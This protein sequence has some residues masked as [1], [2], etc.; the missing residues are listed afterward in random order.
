MPDSNDDP[1]ERIATLIADGADVD[2]EYWRRSGRLTEPELRALKLIESV[3]RAPDKSEEIESAEAKPGDPETGSEVELGRG[4]YGSVFRTLDPLLRREVAVKVLGGGEALSRHDRERFLREARLL[5]TVD[6]PNIVRIYSVEELD[7]EVRLELEFVP[8]S[9]LQE[10]VK[11]RGPLAPVEA[12]HVALDLCRAL[13]AIHG[14]GIVHRDLK[15]S[16][17]IRAP[18]GRIVLL[19]FGIAATMQVGAG[20]M[21]VGAGTPL[22]MAPEQFTGQGG[23]DPR[24]DL[25]SLGA[26][27]YWMVSGHFPFAASTFELV[28]ERVL[29]GKPAPLADHRPD[30]PPEFQ[31]L[32]E[33]ALALRPED[34]FQTA[35]EF[36][37]ALRAFLGG[38]AA[39][40]APMRNT[41]SAPWKPRR[42][43]IFLA[44][45]GALGICACAWLLRSCAD[46]QQEYEFDARL[47]CV[48]ES[49][50]RAL[51]SGD[52][53]HPGDSLAMSM[54][55]SRP[56]YCYVFNEDQ[57]GALFT[58]YPIPQLL[59]ENPLSARTLHRLPG[60]KEGLQTNWVVSDTGGGT[61]YFLVVVSPDPIPDL[62]ELREATP[63][64]GSASGGSSGGLDSASRSLVLR[65]VGGLA[66]EKEPPS[67][68]STE[69]T[70][71]RLAE[72][73]SALDQGGVR[74]SGVTARWIRLRNV[75]R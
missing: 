46:A 43:T 39:P 5:A 61:E 25:Y 20:G 55:C 58:L 50:D 40:A 51:Q 52:E 48:T 47:L 32:V 31:S 26:L 15:P 19:D 23:A 44:L 67:E 36:E 27:L 1:V 53:V 6:H 4:T 8:G 29:S 73:F 7:D 17:V 38:G 65:G 12:A 66:S 21:L 30:L 2:W 22:V 16:N 28:R 62:E 10:S 14:K 74:G 56:L 34:R 41:D 70:P 60:S 72:L 54:R 69:S 57:N 71:R 49:A 63:A 18:G 75:A 35:G 33:Q 42:R 68:D 13:A 37:R 64:A 59:P 9:T 3:H 11:E 45:I 24:S